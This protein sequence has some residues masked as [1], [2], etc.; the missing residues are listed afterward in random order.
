MLYYSFKDFDEF[1]SIFRIEKRDGITVRKNKILLAHLKNPELFRYCQETGDYSLLR[2]KDMAGLRNMVFKAV[3]E[4][5]KEDG[6]GQG[7]LEFPLQ[8][9]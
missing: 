1:K 7:I 2:V 3:C 5:G 8:N 4:S 6:D 9:R